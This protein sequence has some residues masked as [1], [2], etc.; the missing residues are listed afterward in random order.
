MRLIDADAVVA[1][2]CK[3]ATEMSLGV[4]DMPTIDAVEVKR[5]RWIRND[6]NG[7]KIYDCS[8]CGI[9]METDGWNYCPNCGARMDG[10]SDD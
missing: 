2:I 10:E 7:F 3:L 1:Y 6:R 8:V 4:M 5:G 9:H